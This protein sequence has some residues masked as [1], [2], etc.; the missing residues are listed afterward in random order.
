M[1][2]FLSLCLLLCVQPLTAAVQTTFDEVALHPAVFLD[3]PLPATAAVTFDDVNDELDFS[4][5]AA[6][7][8]W[9]ARANAP[10]AWTAIPPGLVTGGSWAAETEVRINDA[11][12]GTQVAGLTFYGGPDNARPDFSF[13]LDVWDA[14]NRAVR[15]QGLGDNNPNAS[16]AVASTVDR[17]ILRMAVSENGASDLYNF[18]FKVNPGDAWTQ[19]GGV[20]LNYTSS[21]TNSR[22]G[23]VYKAGAPRAGAAF[24]YFNVVDTSGPP[25]ILTQPANASVV[26]PGGTSFSVSATGA[27]SYQW[28]KN[29]A[30]IPGATAATYTLSSTTVADNGASFICAVTNPF[31]TTTSN[32][33]TLTVAGPSPATAC[34]RAAVQAEPSLIAY[35]PMDGATTTAIPNIITPAN[36]GTVSGTLAFDSTLARIVGTQAHVG[37]R[38]SH[39]NL[40]KDPRWDFTDGTGTIETWLYQTA[41][42]ADSPCF[43]S[44]R[45]AAATRYSLHTHTSGDMIQLWNGAAVTQWPVTPSLI[46]RLVHVAVVFEGGGAATCYL[47]GVSLGTRVGALVGVTGLTAQIAASTPTGSERTQGTTD[48][49]A[50]YSDAIPAAAIAAHYAS[51]IPGGSGT[52]ASITSQPASMTVGDGGAASFTV[53]LNDFTG[54]SY[55]W[56]RNGVD[57]PDAMGATYTIPSA[58]LSD[59]G[60]Q[61]RCIAYN[62]CGGVLSNAAT[63]TVTDDPAHVVNVQQVGTGMLLVTFNEAVNTATGTW[64]LNHGATITG[65]QPGPSANRYFL[66]TS[67]LVAGTAYTITIAGVQDATGNPMSAPSNTG[68]TGSTFSGNPAPIALVR[69]AREPLGPASRRGGLVISEI[70]YHPAARVDLRNLEFIEIANKLPWAEDLGGFPKSFTTRRPALRSC[71]S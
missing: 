19:I 7:D 32:P 46:G 63:L 55:R 1:K 70:N 49:V 6:T 8:M 48:E 36:S 20:A 29:T 31:G 13:G 51:F 57:I 42:A 28:K 50:I 59:H 16:V 66:L 45:S 69:G 15:L 37:N 53:V 22:V 18:F 26:E 61:F 54:A 3:V 17:V 23:L 41:T 9:G 64:T 14:N 38:N 10:I 33:A 52:L 27:V 24:T 68:F 60:A 39:I 71:H 65:I 21:F 35:F 34:Y 25:V 40:T 44:V 5:T 43:F 30:D 58:Q 2:R 11:T 4:A 12:T 47:N 67:T 62:A 56:Q